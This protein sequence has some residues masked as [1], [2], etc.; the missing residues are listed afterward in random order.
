MHRFVFLARNG[1]KYEIKGPTL[2]GIRV[3]L[4]HEGIT[5]ANG[6]SDITVYR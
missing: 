1:I 2:A 5:A 4:E 6:W 3:K